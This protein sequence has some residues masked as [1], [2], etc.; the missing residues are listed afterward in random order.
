M[1]KIFLIFLTVS[2]FAQQSQIENFYPILSVDSPPL[3]NNCIT[4]SKEEQKKCFEN[5]IN[6]HI[7]EN[8]I[9]PEEAFDNKE[10]GRVLTSFSIDINGTVTNILTRGPNESL[11]NEVERV[12]SIIPKLIPAIKDG[13]AVGVNYALPVNFFILTEF[14]TKEITIKR[15]A[16]IYE[17]PD[18][19]SKKILFILD[20]ST[21]NATKEGDY[22]LADL[23]SEGTYLGYIK[24][25]DVLTVNSVQNIIEKNEVY[26]EEINEYEP[27]NNETK[28]IEEEVEVQVE[29]NDP[30]I[31]ELNNDISKIN[32]YKR[33]LD[34]Q[35][36]INRKIPGINKSD[37]YYTNALNQLIKILEKELE[38]KYTY[39]SIDNPKIFID[40]RFEI[41]N[42]NFILKKAQRFRDKGYLFSSKFLEKNF[43]D[44]PDESNTKRISE[45]TDE[46]DVLN[47][48]TL[49]N[50]NPIVSSS[51]SII[52]NN[53]DE[54]KTDNEYEVYTINNEEPEEIDNSVLED[55]QQINIQL[56]TIEKEEITVDENKNIVFEKGEIEIVSDSSNDNINKDVIQNRTSNREQII[57]QEITVEEARSKLKELLLLYNQD[58]ISRSLYDESSKKLKVIVELDEV[59]T[60]KKLEIPN[61]SREEAMNRI[62]SLKSLLDQGLIDNKTFEESTDIL[63]QI[64]IL[65]MDN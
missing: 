26:Q 50:Y 31:I 53:I 48:V 15:G 19:K 61:I 30:L 44:Y 39:L 45:L 51:E 37:L 56:E 54:I 6:N 36:E 18:N 60:I 11:E 42:L 27:I 20:Q 5:E 2:G 43:Y 9:F 64:I 21:L 16:N 7:Q 8:L 38:I 33:K 4:K 34:D 55:I 29:E 12:L 57:E 23:N 41:K 65:I 1:K 28:P 40:T 32:N 35:K 47:F 14:N 13:A 49:E 10:E 63:K 17:S 3:F 24:N 46:F 58:L 25:S 62:R 22:W 52:N 59:N